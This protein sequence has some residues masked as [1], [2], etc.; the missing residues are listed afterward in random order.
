MMPREST[1]AS[2]ATLFANL[3][4]IPYDFVVR[5]K[6][7]GMNF[8]FYI[9]EQLPVLLPNAYDGAAPW[10]GYVTL[11]D[12]ISPRVLELTYTAHDLAPFARDLGYEGPPFRWDPERRFLLRCEL[13]AAF[14]HLYGIG[15]SDSDYIMETFPIVKRKDEAAHGEYRTKRV[16]LEIYDRM[17]RAAE[18]GEPYR[19]PLDPPPVDL[20]GDRPA[21][22]TPLR[23]RKERYEPRPE[24][25]SHA[26][27]AAEDRRR[28]EPRTRTD[29]PADAHPEGKDSPDL[30]PERQED[31]AAHAAR[32][33]GRD[34]TK[35]AG[36]LA[37]GTHAQSPAPEVPNP[38]D[39]ALAL[40]ACIPDGE[41]VQK[42]ALLADAARELGYP[43]L[44]KKV[45]RALSKVLNVEHNAGRLKTDWQLVWRPRKR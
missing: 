36:G 26:A 4:S 9:V 14:F 18:T 20:G 19:T 10:N 38:Q 27:I 41:K 45:R 44:T 1:P 24:K 17:A 30:V 16:I 43:R 22:V 11:R 13:D 2:T 25:V 3:D 34:Q 15:R 31:N 37:E 28:Y 42:D 40:H 32:S 6:V 8:N 12:W 39:A 23:P 35:P 21:T 7:G 5:Q 33:A 29:A